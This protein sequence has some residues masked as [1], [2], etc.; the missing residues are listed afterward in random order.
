[1]PRSSC[2]S[3]RRRP[4]LTRAI[5]R[6]HPLDE[7]PCQSKS[8]PCWWVGALL[9]LPS[10]ASPPQSHRQPSHQPPPPEF[11]TPLVRSASSHHPIIPVGSQGNGFAWHAHRTPSVLAV[12]TASTSAPCGAAPGHAAH[13]RSMPGARPG[14]R[15]PHA[16][17]VCLG[18]GQAL[19]DPKTSEARPW[20]KISAQVSSRPVRLR[21]QAVVPVS[22]HSANFIYNPLFIF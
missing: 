9:T 18:L 15:W 5:L 13:A 20:V 2:R 4:S 8:L 7:P 3:P 12:K 21:G 1:V 11:S 14:A 22:T 6:R 16:A 17:T 19:S 10:C